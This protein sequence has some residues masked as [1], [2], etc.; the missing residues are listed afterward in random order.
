MVFKYSVVIP[1]MN[2][3]AGLCRALD[4]V[5]N[6]PVDGELEVVV[7]DNC[8]EDNI[9]E[10]LAANPRYSGVRVIRQPHRVNRVENFNTAFQA[11]TGDYVCMLFDDEEMLADNLLRKGKILDQH[12]EVIAVTS[13]V[14]RRDA[15][16]TLKP[17]VLLRE[18]HFTIENR[19]EYLRNSFQKGPGGLLETLMRREAL[20][21]LEMEHQDDPLD[22]NAFVMRL[23]R[24]GSIAILPE[25]YITQTVS[26]GEMIRNGLL[27]AFEVPG[28]PG[29]FVTLPGIW[30]GWCHFRI[31]MEHVL[32]SSDL[33]RRQVRALRRLARRTFRRDVWK[34]AYWRLVV[35]KRLG[36]SLQLLA[37]ASDIDL[38][39]LVPPIK[40]F[41]YWKL[42]KREAPIPVLSLENV[43]PIEKLKQHVTNHSVFQKQH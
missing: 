42:N 15:D 31:R 43:A 7:V 18:G 24:L 29:K 12:P 16:G 34:A 36:P 40:F 22:D 30:F 9:Q 26:E 25:G 37:Q 6:Q 20:E 28:E 39:L 38:R 33:S 2:R 11:A 10:I 41:I 17:G 3:V 21:H 19:F 14:T 13:A 23:S 1:T 27:E 35:S 4:S 32:T 8:S 5:L